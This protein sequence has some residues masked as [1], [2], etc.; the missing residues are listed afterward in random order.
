MVGEGIQ[1]RAWPSLIAAFEVGGLKLMNAINCQGIMSVRS[2]YGINDRLES[3]SVSFHCLLTLDRIGD[4]IQ[5]D[6]LLPEC[7]QLREKIT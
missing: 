5:S 4:W 2:P 6:G 3:R 1:A 7:G